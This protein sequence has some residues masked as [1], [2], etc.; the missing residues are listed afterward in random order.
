MRIRQQQI[1]QIDFVFQEDQSRDHWLS[2][3]MSHDPIQTKI[4]EIFQKAD[5]ENVGSY[6]FFL[7]TNEDPCP[8]F[9]LKDAMSAFFCF[10]RLHDW[11]H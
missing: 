7:T 6:A 10:R 1:P 3:R 9:Q 5:L 8:M 11:L 2:I 4:I